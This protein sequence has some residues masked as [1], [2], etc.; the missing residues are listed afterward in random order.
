MFGSEL[1]DWYVLPRYVAPRMAPT[2]SVCANPVSRLTAVHN[3]PETEFATSASAGTPLVVTDRS[4]RSAA[5]KTRPGDPARRGSSGAGSR[6]RART[7]AARRTPR[8]A[9][10]L[11]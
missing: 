8:R 6:G 10:R 3:A 11:R 9:R 2:V 7:N 1:T 5:L 4:V